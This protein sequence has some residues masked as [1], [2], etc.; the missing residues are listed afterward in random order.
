MQKR[1]NYK[2]QH[3]KLL[4]QFNKPQHN[5]HKTLFDPDTF[6][7]KFNFRS[8]TMSFIDLIPKLSLV[9]LMTSIEPV[10][11]IFKVNCRDL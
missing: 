3:N 8:R 7:L 6:V 2:T 11:K 9:S 1:N 5:L 10:L 4:N